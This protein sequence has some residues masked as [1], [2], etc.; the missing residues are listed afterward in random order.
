MKSLFYLFYFVF[1]IGFLDFF[2]IGFFVSKLGVFKKIDYKITGE[3]IIED[4]SITAS[5]NIKGFLVDEGVNKRRGYSKVVLHEKCIYL[6]NTI[7]TYLLFVAF[8]DV[9]MI[10]ICRERKFVTVKIFCGDN[11]YLMLS[12]KEKKSEEWIEVF[13]QIAAREKIPVRNDV[14]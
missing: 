12:L 4:S 5:T 6:K 10:F 9:S 8:S 13:L 14:A 2:V 3:K 11:E 7:I 1:L